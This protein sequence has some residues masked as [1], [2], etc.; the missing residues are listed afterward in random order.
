[1]PKIM[2]NGCRLHVDIQGD[3]MPLI[4]LHGLG[5]SM[6]SF[7]SD[8]EHFR[9][10]RR[11]IAIDSRGHGASDRPPAYTLQDHIDDVVS[12]ID[13]LDLGKVAVIGSSMGS[14]VAQGAAIAIPDR[15]SRLV[16][17]AAKS[18]GASSSSAVLLKEHADELEG[19]TVQQQRDFLYGKILAPSSTARRAEVLQL[20]CENR[21]SPQTD[22]EYKIAQSAVSNFDFRPRLREISAPTLIISGRY[23]PL[24]PPEQGREIAH[25]ISNSTFLLFENS[26]HLPRLEERV[27][28][29]AAV[30]AFLG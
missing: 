14:Y 11:T 9:V 20:L 18:H 8:I 23:D 15:I 25:Y 13:E 27:R 21:G 19:A 30:D 2:T 22:A 10:T 5:N 29:L 28:Y 26:G 24:N 1:M 16:L 3:G 4:M 17:V 12:V 6:A 7:R